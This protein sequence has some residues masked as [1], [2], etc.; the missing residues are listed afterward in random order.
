MS[1]ESINNDASYS[2]SV[3]SQ[4]I[5]EETWRESSAQFIHDMATPLASIQLTATL[6]NNYLPT[7]LS[8]YQQL[9]KNNHVYD[10]ALAAIPSAHYHMLANAPDQINEMAQHIKQQ[11]KAYWKS[12][13][14]TTSNECASSND[15]HTLQKQ[16]INVLDT[17]ESLRIL[18]AEDDRLHQKIARQLLH[19]HSLDIV[20]NGEEVLLAV[21]EAAKKDRHYDVILMDLSMPVMTGQ[22]AL[23]TLSTGEPIP[24]LIIG[25]T[26]RPLS[27][28]EKQQLHT[29]G[30]V[31]I[32][33]KP[34]VV[35][36]LNGLLTEHLPK[37]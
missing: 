15:N 37:K 22:Q 11:S 17:L 29:Q 23:A 5:D 12:V 2:T 34:L 35:N 3:D 1:N 26:N 28:K 9:Q 13:G 19:Q 14:D 32:L 31:G 36:Q 21:K 25:L 30:C 33:E 24:S 16:S 7:L 18:V 10:E 27:K 4:K 6:L 8:A 20:C